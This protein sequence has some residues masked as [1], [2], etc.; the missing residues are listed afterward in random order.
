MF[1]IIYSPYNHQ[2][3]YKTGQKSFK[4]KTLTSL[5][6]KE[7]LRE[8]LSTSGGVPQILGQFSELKTKTAE[9]EQITT[10]IPS[11]KHKA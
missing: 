3:D 9:Q 5:T 6:W 7:L 2:A 8:I 1:T 10:V 4:L 11:W